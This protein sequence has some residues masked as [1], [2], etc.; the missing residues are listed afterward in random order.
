[1]TKKIYG[2]FSSQIEELS[3]L[4]AEEKKEKEAEEDKIIMR[5]EKTYMKLSSRMKE[6]SRQREANEQEVVNF[7]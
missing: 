3:E 2:Q 1:M 4:L 7:L 6:G 5:L